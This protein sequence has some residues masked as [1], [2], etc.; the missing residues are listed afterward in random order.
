MNDIAVRRNSDLYELVPGRATPTATTPEM[1]SGERAQGGERM[2]NVRNILPKK[3][4]DTGRAMRPFT[5]GMEEFFENAF[6]RRW[7][8][9]FF[10]PY[11]L[12]RPFM[13]DFDEK[14]DLLPKVDIVDKDDALIVRAEV[15]GVK[16]DDLE[17]TIAGDRLVFEAKREFEEEEKKEDFVR[18]E[19]AYGRLYR[20][21]MLPAEVEGDKAKAELKDGVLEIALPKVEATTP[22]K[23]KVA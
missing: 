13:S 12:R 6:P 9:G 11:A 8:E 1:V 10:D 7:M 21:V 16:K 2:P 3:D 14:F 5:H 23:V 22:F 19:M 4:R 18:H 15:P 20:A 17:I